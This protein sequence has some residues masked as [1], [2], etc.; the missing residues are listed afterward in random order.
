MDAQV[1]IARR[2]ARELRPGNLVNLGIGIPTEVA[3]HVPLDREVIFHSENGVIGAGPTPAPDQGHPFLINAGVPPITL[4]TG[5]SYSHP[6]DSFP[7]ARGCPLAL[8]VPGTANGR[9]AQTVFLVGGDMSFPG[10]KIDEIGLSGLQPVGGALMS[11][12]REQKR[13]VTVLAR[14]AADV[15]TPGANAEIPRWI[16]QDLEPAIVGRTA[17]RA[18]HVA[19]RLFDRDRPL[20]LDEVDGVHVAAGARVRLE[21]HHL[22]ARVEEVGAGEA[23]DAGADDRDPHR[24]AMR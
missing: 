18:H 21:E 22:V 11:L 6:A 23:G 20:A 17:I 15:V 10:V 24:G 9:V 13:L 14:Q 3:D 2:V 7:I 5:G 1:V 12:L 19:H 4:R 8:P 16:R